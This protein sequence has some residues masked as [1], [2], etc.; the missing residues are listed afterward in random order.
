MNPPLHLHHLHH[1]YA[2]QAYYGYDVPRLHYSPECR[3][4]HPIPRHN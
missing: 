3:L 2:I 4:L 1:L